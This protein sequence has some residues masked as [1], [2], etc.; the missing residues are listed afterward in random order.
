MGPLQS[1][2]AAL[3]HVRFLAAASDY[4]AVGD[5][6]GL[7][8]EYYGFLNH[9]TPCNFKAV[10]G[11]MSPLFPV[12]ILNKITDGL[13]TTILLGEW[14]GSPDIWQRG[15]RRV[16]L[17][18]SNPQTLHAGKAAWTNGKSNPG[19]CWMCFS[20]G[21]NYIDGSAF[22]GSPYT[23]ISL[24]N[25]IAPCLVNCTNEDYGGLFSF[26]PGS[27]GVVMCDGTAR[28]MSDTVNANVF[29]HLMTP[30]GT[31]PVPDNF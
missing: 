16:P 17:G 27:V 14:A 4:K 25:M 23:S 22:D 20:N 24:A 19:G 5:I 18:S 2:S 11:V 10:S 26:H 8:R 6:S 15:P 12:P 30:A 31:D 29:A 9:I 3:G 28:M 1:C 21:V 13:G 7:Y